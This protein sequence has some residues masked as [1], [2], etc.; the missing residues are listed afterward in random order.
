MAMGHLDRDSKLFS[1]DYRHTV[2]E[3]VDAKHDGLAAA[4]DQRIVDLRRGQPTH[5]RGPLPRSIVTDIAVD[6]VLA[7][8][9]EY[10]E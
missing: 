6:E 5:L 3:I 8:V 9:L 10:F 1:S 7:E 4:I 2:R